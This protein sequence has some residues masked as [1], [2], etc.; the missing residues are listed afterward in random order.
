MAVLIA[1]ADGNFTSAST[2]Q[3]AD[4]TSALSGSTSETSGHVVTTALSGTRTTAFTTPSTPAITIDAIL[5]KLN[6]RTGTT[7]TIKVQLE[8]DSDDSLVTGT[9]VTINCAD[10]PAA[11]GADV[12][13]GWIC[14]KFSSPVTLA[15]STAYQV[16]A[17]T[18]S[19]NQITLWRDSTNLNIARLL[20]TTT[21]QAPVAGDDLVI[22]G[23]K[24]AAGAQT[25]RTVTMNETATTDYGSASTS[26]VVPALAI[27]DGGTLTWGVASTT[28][29]LLKISGNVIIYA[30]GT[31]NQGTSGTPTPSGSSTELRFD[32]ATNVDFGLTVRNLGVDNL[33]G[34]KAITAAYTKLTANAAAGATSLT[35]VDTTGWQDGDQI[36]ISTTTRT[37]TEC[38]DKTSTT[39]TSSTTLGIAAL[40]STHNVTND[41][42]GDTRA[43][44]ASLTRNA[45]RNGASASLQAYIDI[46]PTA[47]VNWSKFELKWLGSGTTLKRGVNV[48]TTTGTFTATLGSLHDFSLVNSEGLLF[49]GASGGSG[50]SVTKNV[51]YNIFTEHISIT[52]LSNWIISDNLFM[53]DGDTTFNAM[54]VFGFTCIGTFDNNIV[55]GSR[56]STGAALW[57]GNQTVWGT[58]N[59]NEFHGSTWAGLGSSASSNQDMGTGTISGGRSYRNGYGV[60]FGYP[61]RSSGIVIDGLNIFGNSAVGLIVSGGGFTVK[62]CVVNA[63]TTLTQPVGMD[64]FGAGTVKVQ[65]CTFGATNTHAT[66]DVRIPTGTNCYSGRTIFQN[67][68]MASSTE[69]SGTTALYDGFIVSIRHDGTVGNNKSWVFGGRASD[70][71]W[72]SDT[73]IYSAA[74]PSLRGYP[75]QV[76]FKMRS[77]PFLAAVTNGTTLSVSV[78]VRESIAGDGTDYN[79]A[80]IRLILLANPAAGIVNDV[81]L[82]TATSSSEGAFET[83]SGTTATVTDDAILEFVVDCDG[84]TGWINV[85][86]FSCV[87]PATGGLKF[88]S[89]A[90]GG[91]KVSGEPASGGGSSQQGYAL[92][93]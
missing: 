82:A 22:C 42:N 56:A 5:I 52:G 39:I 66:S 92:F 76:S 54:I 63:G 29:Y 23:E 71:S 14:F 12:N 55:V 68:T 17:V 24:T 44:V 83:L 11:V 91:P 41:A 79:G 58:W 69:V 78:K 6:T 70:W 49:T 81:V 25:T 34:T 37:A 62:N 4:T 18:S 13:G 40:A 87:S 57:I 61:A 27:C 74:S 31:H 30:G 93:F 43:E 8:K 72:V 2:W 84:T 38:E 64:I 86:D 73:A 67:C 60:S 9:D 33:Y 89:G 77:A 1:A 16:A 47:V 75:G 20:R 46:K 85:D 48:G 26:L 59:G 7:G 19:S 32:C 21:T 45:K 28:A 10:L 90:L 50:I 15:A 65:S 36:A 51:F 88:W 35:V 53:L 3:V 80:R